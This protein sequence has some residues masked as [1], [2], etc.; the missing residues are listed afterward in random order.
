MSAVIPVQKAFDV[1]RKCCYEIMPGNQ[2]LR[3]L[4]KIIGQLE[5]P[6]E[7]LAVSPLRLPRV[8]GPARTP[9]RGLVVFGIPLTSTSP[10]TKALEQLREVRDKVR[11]SDPCEE[12]LG[13][14]AEGFRKS[15]LPQGKSGPGDRIK[16]VD[17]DW[18]RHFMSDPPQRIPKRRQRLVRSEK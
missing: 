13:C 3:V 7:S 5:G 15:Q 2:S 17:L 1:V 12:L 8:F 16:Y 14:V 18:V 11:L 10:L 6:S 4:N 9:S